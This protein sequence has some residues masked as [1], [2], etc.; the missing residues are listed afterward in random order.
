MDNQIRKRRTAQETAAEILY[1][2]ADIVSTRGYASLSLADLAK[3]MMVSPATIH[4]YYGSKLALAER[5]CGLQL[6]NF[7]AYVK[8]ANEREAPFE[9]RLCAISRALAG[10]HWIGPKEAL[11]C[12]DLYVSAWQSEWTV[13]SEFRSEVINVLRKL[14][15]EG[16]TQGEL[17][18]DSPD[19]APAFYDALQIFM[20]PLA[21]R[22]S[23][24]ID[25]AQRATHVAKV[26][27]RA[28]INR[29]D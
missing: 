19:Q 28:V 26:L 15:S 8:S 14:L 7:L 27:C 6:E 5:I 24:P 21:L 11:W 2:A 12:T 4:K 25:A 17:S 23:S 18:P 3:A 29:R 20:H 9:E 1:K 10:Y 22:D 13:F 16:V